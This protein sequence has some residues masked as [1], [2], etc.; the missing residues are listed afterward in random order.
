MASKNSKTDDQK[1]SH[2]EQELATTQAQLSEVLAIL[3]KDIPEV[4]ITDPETDS[5]ETTPDL[6]ETSEEQSA[7]VT[8]LIEPEEEEPEIFVETT[9]N[10]PQNPHISSWEI[11]PSPYSPES[12]IVTFFLGEVPLAH[13]EINSERAGELVE[14]LNKEIAYLGDGINKWYIKTPDNPNVPPLLHLAADEG[15]V[16]TLELNHDLMVEIMPLLLKIYNPL[17]KENRFLGWLKK[18]RI[19]SG[20]L[21]AFFSAIF[22]Y[23]IFTYFF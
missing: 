13:L 15:V 23:T 11:S 5:A 10:Y 1:I 21:I 20:I 12:N 14:N 2:L 19:I 9:Q 3:K 18:H 7:S 8:E 16:S 6:T 17:Q 4:N 22:I